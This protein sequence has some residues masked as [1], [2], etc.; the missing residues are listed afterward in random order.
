MSREKKEL[1][2]KGG[3]VLLR[4]MWR[5]INGSIVQKTAVSVS[6][7]F[8]CALLLLTAL[9][10]TLHSAWMRQRIVEDKEEFVTEIAAMVDDLFENLS[11][12]LIS[13]ANQNSVRW[14]VKNSGGAYDGTWLDHYQE[15][16]MALSSI[17]LFY[18]YIIDVGI[19]D[20]DSNLLFSLTNSF[21][22][23]YNFVESEW[24]QEAMSQSG[25]VK[26]APPHGVGHLMENRA[27]VGNVFTI[28]YPLPAYTGVE[29]YVICEVDASRIS[30]IFKNNTKSLE[31][32]ILADAQG[33]PIY[34]YRS[35]RENGQLE[36]A[37]HA[38][39][40]KGQKQG[41]SPVAFEAGD[42]FYVGC[43]LPETEW[44]L[45]AEI[46]SSLINGSG[47]AIR[48][49]S[50][51]VCAC[52]IVICV[53]L[54]RGVTKRLQNSVESVLGQIASYDGTALV[55]VDRPKGEFHEIAEIRAK[56]EEMTEKV[57]SLINDVYVAKL[58]Q[59]NI[60]LEM[61]INQINP[62]FLYNVLQTIHGTAVLHGDREIEDMIA[63]LGEILHYTIDHTNGETTLA[64]ELQHV[65]NYLGFY[66]RRFPGRFT[67][68]IS[69]EDSLLHHR[70]MKYLLQPIVENSV[71]HGFRD[72]KA[73]G[74]IRIEV[75]RGESA[76]LCE[77]TDNG[78]GIG[79]GRLR[80]IRQNMELA[81]H[82]P[83]VGIAN[84][85]ARIRIRYGPS[86]GIELE[87]REG[88]YTR[89]RIRIPAQ[90]PPE[91]EER[92]V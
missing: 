92:H 44:I 32:Y 1:L 77:V 62:H 34:D 38:L 25:A 20:G 21:N 45:L 8:I 83:A 40:Q 84:T 64:Q 90:D 87:S 86:Y 68:A 27:L 76:L 66:Q 33:K 7:V 88:C 56:F 75:R 51:A 60:E 81:M 53:L 3:G 29:G 72:K 89:V 19:L 42:S 11:I 10:S 28:I 2:G 35:G 69:C 13:L 49:S 48:F 79:A 47:G 50:V 41:G 46:S 30:S 71:K 52:A 22:H 65:Q 24:F 17:H 54:L 14:L 23:R 67:Y 73:G 36:M 26:Y 9:T 31:G 61:L 16:E 37:M 57:H 59:Q 18:D 85:N 12:P 39:E 4:H 82:S 5:K 91:S 6:C 78:C 15:V 74:S 70:V 63:S 55:P 43:F 58:Q 80:E